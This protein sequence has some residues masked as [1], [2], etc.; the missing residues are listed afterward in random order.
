MSSLEFT[1][2]IEYYK[3]DPFGTE[4]DDLRAALLAATVA[5][6]SRGPDQAPFEIEDFM[7]QLGERLL[8]KAAK[9]EVGATELEP[10][11]PEQGAALLAM[12]NAMYGGRDLREE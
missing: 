11:G 2:W 9:E 1:E 12:L 7:L 4:R 3:I 6:A 5:N 10:I 8:L